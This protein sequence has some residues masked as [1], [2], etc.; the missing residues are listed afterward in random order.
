MFF[1]APLL[2]PRRG[3]EELGVVVGHGADLAGRLGGNQPVAHPRRGRVEQLAAGVEPG[4]VRLSVGVE[5][6]DDI[7]ADLESG[8]AAV[9]ARG[10]AAGDAAS[11]AE[12][13]GT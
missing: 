3:P 12:D 8:F 4:F 5:G 1:A 2:G 7:L 11:S 10:D 13:T 9:G 6:I